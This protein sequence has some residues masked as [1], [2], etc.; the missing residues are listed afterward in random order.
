MIKWL[1]YPYVPNQQHKAPSLSA[2]LPLVI[3]CICQGP[4][5]LLLLPLIEC[6]SDLGA[7]QH[8]G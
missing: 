7:Q 2:R 1:R 8:G 5:L 6:V 3:R 4:L